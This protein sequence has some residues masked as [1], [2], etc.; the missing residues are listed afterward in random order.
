MSDLDIVTKNKLLY[1][2][3]KDFEVFKSKFYENGGSKF[4]DNTITEKITLGHSLHG[5]MCINSGI[6]NFEDEYFSSKYINSIKNKILFLRKSG[7]HFE[8]NSLGSSPIADMLLDSV[9]HENMI[10][11]Y[12]DELKID[13]N[14][15]GICVVVSPLEACIM[16]ENFYF[17]K[18]L[19]DL[20]VY[21]DLDLL[22]TYEF[23]NREME[24]KFRIL[25]EKYRGMHNKEPSVDE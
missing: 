15:K 25:F 18:K 11:W 10:L 23:L 19:F 5:L 13:V 22:N 1:L 4:F 6:L 12:I 14:L 20:G 21:P 7:I 24:Q 16:T 3:T 17:M 9:S 8:G 2:Q